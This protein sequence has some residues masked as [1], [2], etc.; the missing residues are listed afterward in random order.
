VTSVELD[1]SSIDGSLQNDSALVEPAD[2]LAAFLGTLAAML[3]ETISKFERTSSKVTD[4][5]VTQPGL[6]DRELVV[7]LQD[8]DRLNQEFA[9][10]CDAL[11]RTG[12]SMTGTWTHSGDDD[13]HPRHKV[14][15]AISIAE[16]RDRM[17]SHLSSEPQEPSV[18]SMLDEP[19]PTTND[20]SLAE[21]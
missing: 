16:L 6:T 12:T 19:L 3:R 17:L 2:D 14:I 8:F 11:A 9:A 13:D 15:G 20:G 21:F 1:Q 5:V 4:L 18:D 10:I 7:A